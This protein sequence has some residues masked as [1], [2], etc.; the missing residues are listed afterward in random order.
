[1]TNRYDVIV[2]G[3]GLNGLVASVVLARSSQRVLLLERREVFGGSVGMEELFPGCGTSLGLSPYTTLLPEVADATGVPLS[4]VRP[5]EGMRDVVVCHQ[6][7]RLRYSPDVAKT[8][9]ELQKHS[10]ADAKA[11]P[12]FIDHFRTYAELLR[13]VLN[14]SPPTDLRPDRQDLWTLLRLGFRMRGLGEESLAEFLRTLPR[15]CH[16]V[17]QDRFETE[18]VG[19]VMAAPAMAHANLA[20]RSPGT[21]FRMLHSLSLGQEPGGVPH[22]GAVCRPGELSLL[23]VEAARARGVEI[24]SGTEV[25][26][27]AVEGDRV[28][29]VTL[30]GGE[31]LLADRVL[32]TLDPKQSLERLPGTDWLS[33][34]LAEELKHYRCQGDTATV[35]F[36]VDRAPRLLLEG[37]PTPAAHALIADGLDGMERSND[38]F[39]YG[40]IAERP[41]IQLTV[42]TQHDP[43]GAPEG[44]HVVSARVESAPY[45]LTEGSWDDS[46]ERLAD[47]VAAGIQEAEPDFSSTVLE[48][49]VLSPADL[50][51]KLGLTGGHLHHG[52]LTLDQFFV[53]R[54]NPLCARY[55]TPLQGLYLG[56]SGTHPGGAN[57]G[58]AGLNAARQMARDAKKSRAKGA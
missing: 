8:R 4:A 30:A 42:P 46:R 24:R 53:L 40:K 35:H 39:K 14:L 51:Q 41:V 47:T 28:T 5:V 49:K 34:G 12:G 50:E 19:M 2:V 1:M 11:L 16:D 44:R 21:G 13:T 37:G 20:P 10:E 17:T 22:P 26:R 52:E 25:E 18:W 33:P 23:M 45:Q 32:S 54:P 31:T 58:L 55:R 6:G 29:G 56:G 38:A 27:F 36:L 9:G 48:R 7:Q 57:G 3:G 43:T 15:P